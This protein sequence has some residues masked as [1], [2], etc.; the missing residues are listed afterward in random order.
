MPEAPIRGPLFAESFSVITYVLRSRPAIR[1]ELSMREP[2]EKFIESKGIMVRVDT[3]SNITRCAF[4][5]F[6]VSI[7]FHLNARVNWT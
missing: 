6:Y 2:E 1:R 5:D 4:I 3:Q 7:D